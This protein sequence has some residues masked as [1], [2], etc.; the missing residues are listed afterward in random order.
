LP[1]DRTLRVVMIAVVVIVV[2]GLVM[3]TLPLTR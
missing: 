3:G 1:R 2:L